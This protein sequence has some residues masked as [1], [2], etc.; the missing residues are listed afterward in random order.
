MYKIC[1]VEDEIKIQK[2][3]KLL[4]ENA[5]Y[6][7]IIIETFQN[8]A[9]QIVEC[10]PDLVLLDVVLPNENGISVC[11]QLRETNKT[12]VI[13]V[14]SKNSS[15]DEL[16]C[17]TLGGDDFI[18]KPYEPLVLL[19]HIAAVLKRSS[20]QEEKVLR[21]QKI[22]LDILTATISYQNKKVELSKNELHILMYLFYHAEQIVTRDELMDNLWGNGNFIDDN[23][24]SINVSRI[25]QKLRSVNLE[26]LIITKRGLGYQLLLKEGKDNEI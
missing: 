19:A 1:I 3:L 2:E 13:F 4:L 20:S 8:I 25:R 6:E 12:P 24:L 26:E 7:V 17:M 5:N 21:Y 22:E 16:E 15:M 18:A 23:T 14:T 10:N 9:L 11:K